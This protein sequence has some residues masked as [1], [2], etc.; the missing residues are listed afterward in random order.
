M[1]SSGTSCTSGA[2]AKQTTSSPPSMLLKNEGNANHDRV[3]S[4]VALFVGE[5]ECAIVASGKENRLAL[6]TV[7]GSLRMEY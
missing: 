2:R 3:I 6:T 4:L 5:I 1:T 7:C